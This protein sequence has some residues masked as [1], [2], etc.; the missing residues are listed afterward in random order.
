MTKSAFN[1]S[2]TRLIQIFA[3]LLVCGLFAQAQSKEDEVPPKKVKIGIFLISLYDFN[4][5]DNTFRSDFWLWYV[6]P[7]SLKYKINPVKTR[8]FINA[9]E[10]TSLNDYPEEKG[11]LMWRTEK[12]RGV[13]NYN[14]D[15]SRFP[16]DKHE[17]K[18][19]IEESLDD[20]DAFIYLPDRSGNS[21]IDNIL[22]E[23]WKVK[24]FSCSTEKKQYNTNFGDPESTIASSVYSRFIAS[25]NI[26][27]D[28]WLIFIKM[29]LGVYVAVL[30]AIISLL[31]R[32]KSDDIFSGRVQVLV[33]TLFAAII[34]HQIVNSML[35][36]KANFTLMDSIHIISYVVI[37]LG[38]L[39][40]L[41]TKRLSN[42]NKQHLAIVLDRVFSI[43][44]LILYSFVNILLI[45]RAA[46]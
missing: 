11:E 12:V 28:S 3:L 4:T 34:N 37:F 29:S 6:Y 23:G 35:G 38:I 2:V 15:M 7:K 44:L 9:K 19:V 25:I 21:N 5:V 13:F 36:Q 8:E 33:G 24:G 45:Y 10:F 18:I 31:M 39:I 16:F 1:F 32:S 43:S 26:Q 46:H 30:I 41:V 40:S 17:L 27:R 14:W 20:Y 42:F 22:I